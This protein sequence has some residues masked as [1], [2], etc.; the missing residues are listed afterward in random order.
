MARHE[1]ISL[2][3]NMGW[4]RRF[5][6]GTSAVAVLFSLSIAIAQFPSFHSRGTS[7]VAGTV[8]FGGPSAPPVPAN[9]SAF[10]AGCTT[11]TVT[12]P[13][14]GSALQVVGSSGAQNTCGRSTTVAAGDFTHT[15]VMYASVT[16]F[17]NSE[18]GVGFSDGTKAEYCAIT[19][20]GTPGPFVIN[21]I[22]DTNLTTVAGA[23]NGDQTLQ[24][25]VGSGPVFFQLNR[26]GTSLKC[27]WS[28]DGVNYITEFND[29]VPFLT[30]DRIAVMIDP[31]GAAKA[32][33]A[34]LAY[35]Q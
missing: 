7:G 32:S 13:G 35:Y 16:G 10:G 26:A 34:I 21:D 27:S 20:I 25:L 14:G 18:V 22:T 23:A 9:W 5:L 12:G 31:R 24:N 1:L 17:A 29:T 3:L 6:A 19:S 30:A 15:F 33:T 11:T 8:F 28:P 4:T 2:V